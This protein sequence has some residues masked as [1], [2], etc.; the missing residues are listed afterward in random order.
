MANSPVLELKLGDAPLG[1][2][3]A[4]VVKPW[5]GIVCWDVRNP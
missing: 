3:D 5:L 4:A 2:P 1:R